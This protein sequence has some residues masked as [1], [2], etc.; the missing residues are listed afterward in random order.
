MGE[1]EYKQ[2]TKLA[3]MFLK[4]TMRIIEILTSI[5]FSMSISFMDQPYHL[6][7]LVLIEISSWPSIAFRFALSKNVLNAAV[8]ER[9]VKSGTHTYELLMSI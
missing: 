5:Y 1:Y 6:P 7:F 8:Y 4:R 2:L 9:M 3:V